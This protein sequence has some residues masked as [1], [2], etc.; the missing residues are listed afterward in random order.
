[1]DM[2]DMAF[3]NSSFDAVFDKGALDALM[4]ENTA[5]IQQ[6]AIKL[7]LEITRL[8]S[9]SGKYFCIT[10]AENYILETL[11]SYFH[12]VGW[13][14][15]IDTIETSSQ[16]PYKPFL[17]IVTRPGEG[18]ETTQ[19]GNI[20]LNFD[21]I[22]CRL[23]SART[24]SSIQN[25][26]QEV[27]QLQQYN[28][29]KFDIGTLC[30]G[31]FE[32]LK[33][34]ATTGASQNIPRFTALIVDGDED[35]MESS[36]RF[37]S[38]LLVPCG[39]EADYQFSS[40]GGLSALARQAQCRRLIAVTCNR[41]HV[42]GSMDE[43]QAELSPVMTT[44]KPSGMPPDELIPY[45]AVAAEEGWESL[46]MGSSTCTGDY[47]VEERP[48]RNHPRAVYR[49]L[50]FLQNQHFI[51]TEVRMIQRLNKGKANSNNKDKKKKKKTTGK[52]KATGDLNEVWDLDL[53]SLDSHHAAVLASIPLSSP[54]LSKGVS[55]NISLDSND[56]VQVL[57][58]GLGGG[59]FPM[60]LRKYLPNAKI[61]VCEIDPDV[62]NIAMEHFGFKRDE[63]LTVVVAEGMEFISKL[64]QSEE[65]NDLSEE[66]LTKLKTV[67]TIGD[68]I[69]EIEPI[70]L[71]SLHGAVPAVSPPLDLIFIDV[72]SK[73][74]SLGMSAPPAEFASIPAIQQMHSLLRPGGLLTI[75][76]V[77]RAEEKFAQLK[78]SIVSVFG[79]QAVYLLKPSSDTVNAILVAVRQPAGRV[80]RVDAKKLINKW[81]TQCSFEEDPHE[82]VDLHLK[83]H[84]IT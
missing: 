48:D 7:F 38:V 19:Y 69:D 25:A 44:L 8:L 29:K 73:D 70:V 64:S 28:Q 21:Q 5:E 43:V 72:D 26:Q 2:T 82:I 34:Y 57:V 47:L 68:D 3:V 18:I 24:A 54:I 83:L 12:S 65:L 60:C 71:S 16:S 67:T 10:L 52:V 22:G 45:L 59:V 79:D 62:E 30:P 17:I 23:L 31:R 42:F 1:M 81:L 40:Q 49:R 27:L 58:V 55:K 11:L 50:I 66:N 77:A 41:P 15:C 56:V 53:N 84:S 78:E 61:V 37:C 32:S 75:N 36:V 20:L 51:Q 9:P 6:K 35:A 46:A 4:S 76:V 14:I 80:T 33:L 13:A 74:P 39:R 63:Q